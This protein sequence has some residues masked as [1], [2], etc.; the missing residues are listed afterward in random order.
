MTWA[1]MLISA[2]FSR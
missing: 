2:H 1:V